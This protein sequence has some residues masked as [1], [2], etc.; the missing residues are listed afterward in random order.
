MLTLENLS[1]RYPNAAQP[2]LDGVSLHAARGSVLG[3]LGPNGAGKTTLVSHLSGALAVQSG[4]ILIDDQPLQT[5]RRRAPTRI[6]IAP[7]EYAFYSMLT[8]AEN[9]ACFAAAARLPRARQRERI[10]A[11]MELA[12]LDAFMAVR[13]ER[14]SGGLKRRLNLAIALLAEP[15]LLLLDEPTVNVDPQTRAFLLKAIR[16]LATGGT[17]VIYA[18]HYIEEVEAIADRVV[19]IDHGRVLRDGALEALLSEG[20]TVLSL[21]ADHLDAQW[22]ADYGEVERD[23]AIWRVR[24]ADGVRPTTVLTALD[25]AGAHVQHADFGRQNLEQLFMALTHHRLRDN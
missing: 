7:Q 8:V 16:A 1:Y 23:G 21:R 14:L 18:S 12:Q 25:A 22:L 5:V 9:L 13:A 3:L 11:C 2:A 15:E 24:L 17:T 20:V 10:A 6:A 4:R 19:I